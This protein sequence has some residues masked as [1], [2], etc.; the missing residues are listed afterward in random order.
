MQEMGSYIVAKVKS[1]IDIVH[2]IRQVLAYTSSKRGIEEMKH[3]IEFNRDEL[4][5]DKNNE[6]WL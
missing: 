2:L 6:I 5:I 3:I 4:R 1:V